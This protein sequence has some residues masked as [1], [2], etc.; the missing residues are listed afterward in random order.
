MN[1]LKAL[2]EERGMKQSELGKLLNVKDAAIS[3]YESGKVPLTGETLIELSKIFGVSIDYILGNDKEY[4]PSYTNYVS[5]ESEFADGF[6]IRI[7]KIMEEHC[8]DADTFSKKSGLHPN[9]INLYIYGSRVPTME[10]LRKIASTLNVTTDYLLDMHSSTTISEEDRD[11][12]KSLTRRE[13]NIIDVFRQL[14]EDNQDIIMG[15][16]KKC[17]KEQ[18]YEGSVATDKS[19]VSKP[20]TNKLGKSLPSNGTEGDIMAG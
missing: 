5:D 12:L 7:R 13:R 14:S 6:R 11:F 9:D 10:D 3:K 17:L 8:I 2:R 1:R 18:R 19:L 4:T 16:L 20:R 15:E